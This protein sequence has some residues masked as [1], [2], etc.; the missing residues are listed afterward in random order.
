M[1][2]QFTT[3]ILPVSLLVFIYDF[4]PGSLDP[5]A[6]PSVLVTLDMSTTGYYNKL[7]LFNVV[8][9]HLNNGQMGEYSV[10]A[11][12][13]TFRALPGKTPVFF[14]FHTI[15]FQSFG[16]LFASYSSAQLNKNSIM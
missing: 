9:G 8:N 14:L 3:I 10:S 7:V 4:R 15:L 1:N 11:E 13:F 12:G 2:V 16:G 6:S 5:R